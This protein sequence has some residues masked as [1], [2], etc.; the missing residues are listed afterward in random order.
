MR[1]EE[2]KREK[3]C[4]QN[5]EEISKLEFVKI[6][7]HTCIFVNVCQHYHNQYSLAIRLNTTIYLYVFRVG[8]VNVRHKPFSLDEK[9][10]RI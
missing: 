8:Q 2:D 4:A 3:E 6:C 10:K 7:V 1:R 5:S 9:R